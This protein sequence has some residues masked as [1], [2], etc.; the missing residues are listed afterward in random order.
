MVALPLAIQGCV[1]NNIFSPLHAVS[2]VVD[3][4]A[5][6]DGARADLLS[7]DSARI[8]AAKDSAKSIYE[9]EG[10]TPLGIEARIVYAQAAF[11]SA[12]LNIPK[13][14]LDSL[15]A[16]NKNFIETDPTTGK[17]AFDAQASGV[18]DSAETIIGGGGLDQSMAATATDPIAG[19]DVLVNGFASVDNVLDKVQGL[20]NYFADFL[21]NQPTDPTVPGI[22]AVGEGSLVGTLYEAVAEITGVMEFGFE[23]DASG[24]VTYKDPACLT[25]PAIICSPNVKVKKVIKDG[26]LTKSTLETPDD[27]ATTNVNE[28]K[29]KVE[30]IADDPQIRVYLGTASFLGI[31]GALDVNLDG[32]IDSSDITQLGGGFIDKTRTD[33]QASQSG[34]SSSAAVAK[35]IRATILDSINGITGATGALTGIADAYNDTLTDPNKTLRTG[36]RI[37][38]T[39]ITVTSI[40]DIPTALGSGGIV[41]FVS[42]LSAGVSQLDPTTGLP[43]IPNLDVTSLLDGSWAI[44]STTLVSSLDTVATNLLTVGTSIINPDPSCDPGSK[45]TANGDVVFLADPTPCDLAGVLSNIIVYSVDAIGSQVEESGVIYAVILLTDNVE[46]VVAAVQGRINIADESFS[47]ASDEELR[48]ID[49]SLAEAKSALSAATK[50]MNDFLGPALT[51]LPFGEIKN[52][53]VGVAGA[54]DTIKSLVGTLINGARGVLRIVGAP[55]EGSFVT[56]TKDGGT[57]DETAGSLGSIKNTIGGI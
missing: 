14:A 26:V 53:L 54:L 16:I 10:N 5:Q 39:P 35:T 50:T 56:L 51:E 9:R 22:N 7:G 11:A 34:L 38:Y 30:P 18:T 25:N 40:S 15:D 27:P 20:I 4:K 19:I 43:S 17:N 13:V 46:S 42:S 57:I 32:K 3:P 1:N 49:T 12:N 55:A 21:G 2:G 44:R 33:L 52:T 41:G 37:T 48:R 28:E 31:I 6:L 36:T 23:T 45:L 8:Q 47:G 24:D 29:W